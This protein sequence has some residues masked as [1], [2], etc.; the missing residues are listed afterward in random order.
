MQFLAANYFFELWK[1]KGIR[2]ESV[3]G[4][5]LLNNFQVGH[6]KGNLLKIMIMKDIR[7]RGALMPYRAQ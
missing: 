6:Q 2:G 5:V 1:E 7:W 4:A 3:Y